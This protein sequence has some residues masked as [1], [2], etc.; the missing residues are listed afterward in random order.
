MV[1]TLKLFLMTIFLLSLCGCKLQSGGDPNILIIITDDQGWGDVGIH[2]NKIIS[3]PNMDNLSKSG[4]NFDRFFVSP[5]CAPTRASL[6]TGKYFMAAG[7]SGVTGGREVMNSEEYTIAEML[8]D[9]GYSTGCFGKWHNGSHYPHTPLG[10]GFEKFVGFTAG[11]WNNYFDT[12][13]IFDNERKKT[14][15]Y[16]ND[17]VT[18]E[19]IK[20]IQKN[21]SNKFFTYLAYNTPHTPF[22]VP[23]EFF[24]KY[25]KMGLENDLAA[26]YGMCENIDYNIG[27]VINELINQDIYENTIVLFLGDNGPNTKRY[28]GN[29]KG[30]KAST[31]EGGVRVPGFLSWPNNINPNKQ[32]FENVAHIDIM[33]TIASI[34]NINPEIEFD[35][36]DLS[37]IIFVKEK[38]DWSNRNIYQHWAGKGA[39]RNDRYRYVKNMDGSEELYDMIRDPNQEND[40]S[41]VDEKTISEMG[42]DY[43][44]WLKTVSKN[45][46]INRAIPIA[47]DNNVI[48]IECIEGAKNGELKYYEGHGWAN[49][50]VINWGGKSNNIVWN[51]HSKKSKDYFI[52]VSY[53]CPSSSVGNEICLEVEGI[54]IRGNIEEEFDPPLIDSPDR[55]KRKEVYE[56]MWAGLE[57]GQITINEGNN[58][59]IL[60]VDGE[61]SSDIEIKSIILTPVK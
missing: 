54:K 13:L 1:K 50:W 51:T 36:R 56:K 35:G 43:D 20:F 6:L 48:E 21:S 40:I 59:L 45:I 8:K 55:V 31:H 46:D 61:T 18:D 60:Y 32:I 37:P 25:K 49:D 33:P 30:R 58:K 28:N 29:M 27:R 26:V 3:T 23:D 14:N 38:T 34:L 17:V 22:Q 10:Q 47:Y 19:A 12:E 2:E 4:I 53:T 39:V 9:N 57:L 5:V 42:F 52:K 44:S 24:D 15:G 7:V 16:I 11:H 41:E